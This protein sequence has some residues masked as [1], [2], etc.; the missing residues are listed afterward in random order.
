ME[1]ILEMLY[2]GDISPCDQSH[3]ENPHYRELCRRSL[4][5]ADCFAASLDQEKRE[6]FDALM[7]HYLEICYMEKTQAF[8]DGFRLGARIMSDVFYGGRAC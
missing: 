2:N 6:Q 1:R 8:T 5:E 4:D 7:E 3:C